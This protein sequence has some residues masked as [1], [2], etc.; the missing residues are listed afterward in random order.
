MYRAIDTAKACGADVWKTQW[1]SSAIAL[2]R[3]RRAPD[4]LARY[5]LIQW[6]RDWHALLK[7]HCDRVGI[8]YGCTVYLPQDVPVIAPFVERF[9][10]SSF[11]ARDAALWRQL[12]RSRK[13]KLVSV[14]MLG[15]RTGSWG[16][17]RRLRRTDTLLYCVT[18]YPVPAEQLRLHSLR[19]TAVLTR[20]NVGLSD[21]TRSLVTGALAVALGATVIEKH[22][23]LDDTRP[24]NADYPVS[25]DPG[26]FRDYVRYIRE[27]EVV[28][29]RPGSRKRVQPCERHYLRFRVR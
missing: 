12:V 2:A 20:G 25:L 8:E 29:G 4:Y 6:P 11:E 24:S 22:V 3:Q 1:T 28:L 26:A 9:K 16:V 23:R 27:A 21:H 18:G 15:H 13:P 7:D 14:G 19:Q 10:V 17:A 5:R